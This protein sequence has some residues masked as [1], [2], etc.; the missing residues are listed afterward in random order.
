MT[1]R[2]RVELTLLGQPLIIRTEA[3]PEYLRTL[4]TFIEER[5]ATLR[6][7]GVRDTMMALTLATLDIADELFR[8]RDE[9]VRREH[10]VGQRLGA[11]ASLID[12]L[13]A[14]SSG[15]ARPGETS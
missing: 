15:E 10:E 11:L 12:G 1:E 5:V 14:E 6:Q 4:A 3:A 2:S 7:S 8:L 13:A 9:G